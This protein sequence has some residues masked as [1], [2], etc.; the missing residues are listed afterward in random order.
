MRRRSAD[1]TGVDG[2]SRSEN[3]QEPPTVRMATM[4]DAEAIARILAEA[5][6]S[7]YRSTFGRI[8]PYAV[9][10]LLAAL[11]HAGNLSL[12]TTR[13]AERSGVVVGVAILH[14]GKSIGRG[15]PGTYWH[16]LQRQL[17]W[18]RRLRAFMGGL[19]ANAMLDR[20]IPRAADLVYIEA[21]AVLAA[22]RGR[23]V[24]SLL[25]QDAADW[26]LENRRKRLALHVLSTNYRARRLYER[27]GFRPWHGMEGGHGPQWMSPPKR[28]S[29]WTAVL[30]LRRLDTS[31]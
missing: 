25:L 14:L 4:A 2:P 9:A 20:R 29:G 19:A 6:P 24:G 17:P 30:M 18:W 26:A 10:R 23:G 13:V 28:R 31:L 7:L 27:V 3:R 12:E 5:F 8:E 16:T 1:G 11:Y 15:T 21:L 22:A